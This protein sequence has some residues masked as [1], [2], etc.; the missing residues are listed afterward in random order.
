[1]LG[2]ALFGRRRTTRSQTRERYQDGD[3]TDPAAAI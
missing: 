2:R 1:V 3:T